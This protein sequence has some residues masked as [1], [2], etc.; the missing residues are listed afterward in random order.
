MLVVVVVVVV[1][2]IVVIIP[3]LFHLLVG[4]IPVVATKSELKVEP[5]QKFPSHSYPTS[6]ILSILPYPVLFYS[7]YLVVVPPHIIV[8]KV[9]YKNMG[10]V[11]CT[12]YNV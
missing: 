5:S 12:L 6:S 9:I 3:F 2:I 7:S 4:C 8:L 11:Y 1:T 10:Y